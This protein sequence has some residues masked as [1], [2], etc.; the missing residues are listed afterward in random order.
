[1]LDPRSNEVLVRA[2]SDDPFAYSLALGCGNCAAFEWCGGLSVR[3]SVWD[4]LDFC[5]GKPDQCTNV[6]VK[7]PRQFV[8]QKR[9]I[10]GFDLS[11]IP[12]VPGNYQALTHD[13]VP[14]IYHR[15]GRQRAVAG[16]AFALRLY[17]VVDFVRGEVRFAT[18]A[19][20]CD[21]FKIDPSATIILS[22]VDHDERIEP[23][24]T[25]Q[26]RR[27]HVFQQLRD[28]GIELVTSP[29]FSLLLD[30]PRTDDLHAIKRI[31]IV[32]SEF[33]QHGIACALH[34]N[35]RTLKDFER[36]GEF[37]KERTEIGI[38]S[39]EFVTGAGKKTRRQF[40]IDGL[41]RIARC[42]G[43]PLDIVV[44]GDPDV[45]AHLLRDFRHVIYIDTMGYMKTI[46]RQRALRF[47][48]S[49]L[50][51]VTVQTKMPSELDEML[52]HN[53]SEQS[54]FL[55]GRFYDQDM[56]SVQR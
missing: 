4:C 56:A 40:H 23:W 49:K 35:S 52:E 13:V 45:V 5:C 6:C 7:N 55:S 43:R 53:L 34:V 44:R 29:N 39:Y 25:L 30:K 12:R 22:G 42:A 9:E 27:S 50:K 31:A 2:L 32:W 41:Q 47:N 37:V 24:W 46:K 48:N 28:L 21:A 3:D 10:L 15:T 26:D 18:R 1:M 17:D 54:L 19:L 16:S 51:W 36:W 14:L 11:N 20:L 33:E 38:I 8:D